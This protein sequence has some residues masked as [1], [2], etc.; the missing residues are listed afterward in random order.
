M[1]NT[2]NAFD[3]HPIAPSELNALCAGMPFRPRA[4]HEHRLERQRIGEGRYLVAWRAGQPVGHVF[5]GWRELF[6]PFALRAGCPWVTDL[7]VHPDARSQGVGSALLSAC[8]AAAEERHAARIALNVGTSNDHALALY[9]SHGFYDAGYGTQ[10]IYGGW[11][12]DDGVPHRWEEV[13]ICMMKPLAP[14]GREASAHELR[15]I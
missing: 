5:V 2:T 15:Q 4:Q 7:F 10:R 13:V 8:E 1:L 14:L 11:L 3:V 6:D 12:D 9:R